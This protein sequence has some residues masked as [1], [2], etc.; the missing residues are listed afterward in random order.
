AAVAFAGHL[1]GGQCVFFRRG[2]RLYPG[3]WFNR[4]TGLRFDVGATKL[5]VSLGLGDTLPLRW[6]CPR[7]VVTLDLTA[8]ACGSA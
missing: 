2:A 4:W 6:N 3:A 8:A 7:E 5:F 1:H